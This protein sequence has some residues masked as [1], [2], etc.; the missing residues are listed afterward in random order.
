LAINT[1]KEENAMSIYIWGFDESYPEKAIAEYD[2]EQ[3]PDR[4]QFKRGEAISEPQP[5]LVFEIET[6]LSVFQRF[7]HLDNNARLPLISPKLQMLFNGYCPDDVQYLDTIIHYK[8]GMTTDYKAVNITHDVT[9]VDR[10]QS[11]YTTFDDDDDDDISSFERLVLLPNCLKNHQL[12]RMQEY[13]P[14]LLVSEKLAG[15]FARHK[16][17]GIALDTPEEAIRLF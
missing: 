9:A 5:P 4:F 8:G 15:L 7:D 13:H 3:S 1:N 11:V 16:I 14:K 12:A 10:Q 6:P 2:R 17:K